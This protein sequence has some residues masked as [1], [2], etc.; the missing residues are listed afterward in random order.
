MGDARR[1]AYV[2]PEHTD[3]RLVIAVVYEQRRASMASR[4]GLGCLP[5]RARLLLRA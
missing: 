3:V 5:R 1:H 2:F 4:V